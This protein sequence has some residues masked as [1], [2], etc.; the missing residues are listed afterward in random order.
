MTREHHRL[1]PDGDSTHVVR[2]AI[3][4]FS[5]SNACSSVDRS[6]KSFWNTPRIGTVQLAVTRW[7]GACAMYACGHGGGRG[8]RGNENM[9]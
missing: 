1:L 6:D 8:G 9:R 4:E 2:F 3:N 7:S 5:R